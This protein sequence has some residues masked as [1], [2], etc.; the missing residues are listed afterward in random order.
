MKLKDKIGM[1]I[2]GFMYPYIQNYT[3][4]SGGTMPKIGLENEYY[5]LQEKYL[6][7]LGNEELLADFYATRTQ[8]SLT[9]DTKAS[10]YYSNLDNRTRILHSGLPALCSYAKA[11]LLLSGGLDIDVKVKD[12]ELEKE[13]EVLE[14]ILIDNDYKTFIKNLI[15][16]ESWGG[17]FAVKFS[18]DKEVSEYPIMEKYS[19]LSYKAIKKRGRLQELVFIEHYGKY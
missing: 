10:Y 4:E 8:N 11:N 9:I 17:R 5:N 15:T 2:T 12:K 18:I 16:T 6:W 7:F 19:P 14:N 1:G 3:K 13:E